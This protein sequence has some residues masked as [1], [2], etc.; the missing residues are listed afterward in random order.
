[1]NLRQR[2]AQTTV[3]NQALV[4]TSILVALGTLF[5]AGAAIVQVRLMN[6]SE[7]HTDEQIGQIIEN[8]NW[9]ARSMDQSVR[10]SESINRQIT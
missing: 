10:D 6:E 1:M 8:E 9:M 4:A 5:Y 2:W 7:K 3:A